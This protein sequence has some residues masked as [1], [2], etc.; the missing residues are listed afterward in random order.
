MSFSA[1]R[2]LKNFFL[3][4]YSLNLV[5]ISQTVVLIALFI[6][7]NCIKVSSAQNRINPVGNRLIL[8]YNKCI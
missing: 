1:V 5:S 4:N 6:I 2:Y 7:P 8:L 3:N